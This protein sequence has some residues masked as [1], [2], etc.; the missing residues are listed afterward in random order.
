M[1][2]RFLSP[3]Q[4][5]LAHAIEYYEAAVPGLG[6]QFLAEVE[7]T[8]QRIVRNPEAWLK[9]TSTSRRCR[10]RRFPY[11]VFYAIHGKE[12]VISGVMDLRRHPDSWNAQSIEHTER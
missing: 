11:A 3:S 10:L 12:I 9:V 5:D 7:R 6:M 8:V 1:T 2:Y 4:T